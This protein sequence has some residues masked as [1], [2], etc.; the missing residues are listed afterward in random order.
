MLLNRRGHGHAKGQHDS[1]DESPND[2]GEFVHHDW[3]T[4]RTRVGPATGLERDPYSEPDLVSRKTG[5]KVDRIPSHQLI[6][7]E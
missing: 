3:R 5:K 2:Y 1:D 7:Q 6:D 4:Y